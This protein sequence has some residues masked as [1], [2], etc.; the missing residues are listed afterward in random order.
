[1][2][3]IQLIIEK[4]SYQKYKFNLLEKIKMMD[5]IKYFLLDIRLLKQRKNLK[6]T[7]I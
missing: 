4:A 2:K 3:A 7:K 1:M 5:Y 6:F